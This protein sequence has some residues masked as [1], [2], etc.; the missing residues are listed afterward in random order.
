MSGIKS[1]N[2]ARIAFP[3]TTVKLSGAVKRLTY[4]EWLVYICAAF[5][6]FFIEAS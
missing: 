2:L 6:P 3:E 4:P 1:F 5:S